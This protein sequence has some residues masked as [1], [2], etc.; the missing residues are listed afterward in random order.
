MTRKVAAHRS[1]CQATSSGPPFSRPLILFLQSQLCHRKTDRLTAALGLLMAAQTYGTQAKLTA[2]A[3]WMNNWKCGPPKCIPT[4]QKKYRER[5]YQ[6][7][8]KGHAG[9]CES[10]PHRHSRNV[11][12][13]GTVKRDALI[14][15]ML[16]K[17]KMTP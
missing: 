7:S 14:F 11:L 16:W 13:V 2:N 6:L 12:V 8:A 1:Q 5:T 3:L 4:T 10:T 17:D 9:P 15:K